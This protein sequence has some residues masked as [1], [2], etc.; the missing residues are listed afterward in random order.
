M[1]SD[2][3]KPHG[4]GPA[5]FL[6]A[7]G[8]RA[9][10][11]RMAAMA[12][13]I[14]AGIVLAGFVASLMILP[15]LT[16][17]SVV[18]PAASVVAR[19]T[20]GAER[21]LLNYIAHRKRPASQVASTNG[22]PIAGAWFAPWEDGALDSFTRHA[23]DLTH[24]YP[25]WIELRDDGGDI[26][27]KDWDPTRNPT[28]KPLIAAARAHGVKIVPVV[29]NATE[30]HFDAG[31]IDRMLS[32]ANAQHVMDRL[33]GFV[34]AN[35]FSGLQIDFEQVTPQ[36]IERLTPWLE[37]LRQRLHA[38]GGE[39]SIALEVGLS[40][41]DIRALSSV[42]D[43]AAIMAYDEHGEDSLPGPI[44]SA[45]FVDK[46]LTR[47]TQLAPADKLILGI[48]AYSYDWR[49]GDRSAES[50]TT[51][52]ALA[53]ARGYRPE[54]NPA[55]VVDFDPQALQPT[56]RY[57]DDQ[58]RAHEVWMQDAASVA[59]AMTMGRGRGLRGAALWA[60][61]EEDPASWKVF[62]R[63]AA[64][65]I[66]VIPA[67][68]HVALTQQI[69]FT[70]QGELLNVIDTPHAG[71]RRIAVDPVSGLISDEVW[72]RWPSA[73]T[74]RRTGAPDRTLA[75]TF[76]DGPDPE[77]TPEIL[78]VLKAKGVKAT[79]FMIG[80][81]AA[82][83]PDLVRRVRDEGHEIGNHSF[84]HPN[85][86][87]V[88]EER[89][90]LELTAT[91]RALESILGRQVTLFRPPYN[92]DSEPE[93]Y[94]EILP[95]AVASKLGYTTAGESID[96]NDWN[97]SRP[98]PGGGTHRLRPDEIVADVLAQA[99][100]G[101]AILLHDAGGDR[102][103][104]V[105]ALPVLIDALRARGYRL[106]TIGG[107]VGRTP[108]QTMPAL[109]KGERSLIAAD[110]AAFGFSHAVGVVLFVGFNLAIG[111]G[112]AR[113]V[114][115]LALASR[116]RRRAEP[117][118][119][120]APKP[121]VDVLVAAYNE[122][123]VIHR[124][125]DSLLAS[126]DVDV[127][128]IVV[129]DGS[130]DGTYDVVK[131]AFGNDPR[132]RLRRKANGGKASA[133]NL[134][135]TEAT[136]PVVVGVDADTQLSGDA[137]A[138]LAAWFADRKVG[139]VAGNVKVGNRSNLVTRWQSIEYITSQNIDRRALALLN[140][141]TVVPGAIGAWRTDALRNLGGYRSDTLAED[142]DLT[143]RVHEAGWV[144]A[145]EPTA[146][147]FTEAPSS[148]GGLL[149]QRFRW[150]FGTLQCLWKHRRSTF[151]HGWFGGLALPSLWLF[152]IVGQVLAP[153]IDL[154]LAA[155]ILMQGLAW[156]AAAQH[157]DVDAAPNPTLWFTL[158]VYVAFTLLELA[159]GWVAFGFDPERRGDLWLLPT[160]RFVYRQIMYVVV[161]RALERA[162]SGLGQTWG[163][164]K[165]TGDVQ[166][167]AG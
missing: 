8:R 134:A 153:L 60:L 146:L 30:G 142:M 149:K 10:R 84:T 160:Q 73:W 5:V 110:S 75:L 113:I 156:L 45:L 55:N 42:V 11:M 98:N 72:T 67:L 148:L 28:T 53:T 164:L 16:G 161:W 9:R 88:D 115:M 139:A 141:V 49:D 87:H 83:N 2:A 18:S 38:Q 152:Q 120:A 37:Q 154:Q 143:W 14:V 136:A 15:S 151:R 105:K 147:A 40:D 114:L 157:A 96:P 162:L 68:E 128:V 32:P 63:Q 99:D 6:D 124:T 33:V 52:A 117:L 74:V 140:A 12:A 31:R 122:A 150:S 138:R 57:T 116:R 144:I 127:S 46:A 133:L 166:A 126:R 95:I 85:M 89:V 119:P 106:T 159:A 43:Y 23:G 64:P 7:T 82:A 123:M 1:T 86:A 103:A 111:L 62:G 121:R 71:D 59:N 158:G 17:L 76:D 93:S 102:S 79:F 97:L 13:A 47:F 92:A 104:T 101:Y 34:Q 25:T 100:A 129:D 109:P 90:R 51:T 26:L 125:L 80:G 137:L 131:T 27:T 135:L 24:V 130:S 91:D 107:L 132:V 155:A 108:D 44:S 41:H 61:G 39:L 56:F 70:G 163:K 50:L 69:A 29:G 21:A 78:D 77:W 35:G 66:T 4:D 20:H 81:S 112:L 94:G 58:G 54:D 165:R 22:A 145:N 167:P 3:S 19:R 118:D 48:G 36:Q 65:A